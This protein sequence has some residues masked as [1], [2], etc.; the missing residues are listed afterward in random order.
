MLASLLLIATIPSEPS[1]VRVDCAELNHVVRWCDD[2]CQYKES[3]C[4]WILWDWS[5]RHKRYV[6][7]DWVLFKGSHHTRTSC[8]FVLILRSR[9]GGR[10]VVVS[11]LM[12][13]ETWTL[14]DPEIDNREL[15]P[16][17]SRRGV[18]SD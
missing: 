1:H 15:V 14:S 18:L 4:Q 16:S 7:A 11:P 10:V 8:G 13:Q 6:V 12:V 2:T 5:P 3:L 9:T 17:Q